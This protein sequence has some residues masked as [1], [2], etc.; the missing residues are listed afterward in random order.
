MIVGAGRRDVIP[1]L[2]RPPDAIQRFAAVRAGTIERGRLAPKRT[3][4]TKRGIKLDNIGSG[5]VESNGWLECGLDF[6]GFRN[7][8]EP[9]RAG[10]PT[11]SIPSMPKYYV[12]VADNRGAVRIPSAGR[13]SVFADC[14]LQ[15]ALHIHQHLLRAC[16]DGKTAEAKELIDD[17]T[18]VN[19][20]E[21]GMTPLLWAIKNGNMEIVML[22]IKNKKCN[23]N[24]TDV[25]GDTPFVYAYRNNNTDAVR[26]LV[27]AGCD[28]T[29]P[30]YKSKS[31]AERA[32]DFRYLAI[33]EYLANQ[34]PRV[35]SE[36]PRRPSGR[37][38]REK[39]EVEAEKKRI[40]DLMSRK[41]SS[42]S[43]GKELREYLELR[44]VEL[45][46]TGGR[47]I[48]IDLVVKEGYDGK[49]LF[50]ATKD[51]LNRCIQNNP[52]EVS[53]DSRARRHHAMKNVNAVWCVLRDAISKLREWEEGAGSSRQQVP[54]PTPSG[55]RKRKS[56]HPDSQEEKQP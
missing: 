44:A 16:R 43:S 25:F 56:M 9:S 39:E 46:L 40:E 24:V 48:V 2:A 51:K 52:R 6:P 13:A 7:P 50:K 37:A 53:W 54:E 32:K 8:W 19:L 55:S 29:I 14:A 31:A 34:A 21:D 1:R 20:M 17:E 15:C 11:K 30:G 26:A 28:I 41:P 42:L 47:R 5:F 10:K 38:A 23:L 18:N 49:T 33:A 3:D 4:L 12:Y 45:G 22:L 35:Q 36:I 27:E